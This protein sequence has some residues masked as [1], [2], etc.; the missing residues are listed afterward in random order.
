MIYDRYDI[1]IIHILNVEYI[2]TY[3]EKTRTS[4]GASLLSRDNQQFEWMTVAYT[5]KNDARETRNT[6]SHRNGCQMILLKS[7]NI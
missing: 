6:E 7:L 2:C 3:Q 5:K 1:S 4:L